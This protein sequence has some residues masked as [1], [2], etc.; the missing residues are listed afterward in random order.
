MIP[1]YPG[2]KAVVKD[3]RKQKYTEIDD[4]DFIV[5]PLRQMRLLDSVYGLDDECEFEKN[6][7]NFGDEEDL[8]DSD[9]ATDRRCKNS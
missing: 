6:M 3:Y 1:D 7:Y 8:P 5:K 4:N 9:R 2:G